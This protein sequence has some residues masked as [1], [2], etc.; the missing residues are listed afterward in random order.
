MARANS[1]SIALESHN[2]YDGLFQSTLVDRPDGSLFRISSFDVFPQH[3]RDINFDP[4]ISGVR[5]DLTLVD[6]ADVAHGLSVFYPGH[7]RDT[8]VSATRFHVDLV[9]LG[10]NYDVKYMLTF[11]EVAGRYPLQFDNFNVATVTAGVPEPA[12]WAMMLIGFTGLGYAARR[13]GAALA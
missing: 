5:I 6:G 2:F 10:V 7:T 13:R 9:A 11:N 3:T 4:F 8:P 1:G 12:T